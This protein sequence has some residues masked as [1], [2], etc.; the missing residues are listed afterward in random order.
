MKPQDETPITLIES[1]TAFMRDKMAIPLELIEVLRPFEVSRAATS[2][3]K[4]PI[5]IVF[6]TAESRDFFM[7]SQTFLNSERAAK[8]HDIWIQAKYPIH[9]QPLKKKLDL[10]CKRIREIEHEVEGQIVNCFH[11]QVRYSEEMKLAVWV[12]NILDEKGWRSLSDTVADIGSEFP[13]L[14]LA[15][16]N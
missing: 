3:N 2:W 8:K 16:S 4:K 11:S 14:A 5:E 9:W 12:R 13:G 7:S 15:A 10:Q 1:V 6:S